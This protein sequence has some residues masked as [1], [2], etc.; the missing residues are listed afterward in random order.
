[1]AC[2]SGQ[3][4]TDLANILTFKL[5]SK[6]R[7]SG[8]NLPQRSVYV[9][10]YYKSHQCDTVENHTVS[11]LSSLLTPISSKV[12][13]LVRLLFVLNVAVQTT[14]VTSCFAST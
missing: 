11:A 13:H 5:H 12:L 6:Y 2:A 3:V 10:C 9:S 1:M 4:V 8:E 7:V 14:V